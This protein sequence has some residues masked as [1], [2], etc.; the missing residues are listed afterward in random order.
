[1]YIAS[2]NN[3]LTCVINDGEKDKEKPY[4]EQHRYYSRSGIEMRLIAAH[5]ITKAKLSVKTSEIIHVL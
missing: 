3:T 4:E 2:V 1:M 5:D